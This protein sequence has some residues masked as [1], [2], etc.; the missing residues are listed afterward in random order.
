MCSLPA[1]APCPGWPG[2]RQRR[3]GC[4][5]QVCCRSWLQ[6]AGECVP[7]ARR[8]HIPATGSACWQTRQSRLPD[9]QAL[10]YLV[11]QV[12]AGAQLQQHR[13]AL[14]PPAP[15]QAPRSSRQVQCRVAGV[16]QQANLQ[17][18]ASNMLPDLADLLRRAR[19][20]ISGAAW[21]H[22]RAGVQADAQHAQDADHVGGGPGTPPHAGASARPG[23][24]LAPVTNL[25][26][27]CCY[28]NG[29]H[30]HT[31]QCRLPLSAP[32]PP[33]APSARRAQSAAGSGSWA[34]R[35]P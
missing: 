32:S 27:H 33:F 28:A 19:S 8:S 3:A 22:P 1:V 2:G 29:K 21:A 9:R 35:G 24:R 15:V 17:L 20:A 23:S 34:R 5:A 4:Q 6:C 10:R 13:Q 7:P 25:C 26:M 12:C 11:D 18:H 30:W 31:M 16:L 14:L